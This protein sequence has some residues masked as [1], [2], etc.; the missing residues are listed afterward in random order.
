MEREG[1]R[2]FMEEQVLCSHQYLAPKLHMETA[3]LM[4]T[5]AGGDVPISLI[6]SFFNRDYSSALQKEIQLVQ[7]VSPFSIGP[8][9]K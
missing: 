1:L 8:D 2:C 9:G 7:A 5:S 6:V 3:P 4:Y